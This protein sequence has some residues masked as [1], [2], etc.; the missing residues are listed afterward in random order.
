MSDPITGDKLAD[1]VALF[2]F[3]VVD[4]EGPCDHALVFGSTII[5][6]KLPFDI[7]HRAAFVLNQ[8]MTSA[9]K[10]IREMGSSL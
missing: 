3:N 7:V 9:R 1:K 6:T 4:G 5:D 8:A 2:A 10:E